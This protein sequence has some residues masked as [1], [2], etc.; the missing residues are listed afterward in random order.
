MRGC[1]L[2]TEKISMQ[3]Q[4]RQ[5]ALGKVDLFVSFIVF[6]SLHDILYQHSLKCQHKDGIITTGLMIYAMFSKY[7]LTH[8]DELVSHGFRA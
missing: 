8:Q 7:C 6:C 4:R 5:H 1:P 2:W 3:N